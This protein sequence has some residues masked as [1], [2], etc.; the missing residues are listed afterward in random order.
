MIIVRLTGGLGNQ[1]FQY[2]MGRKLA[3]NHKTEL[4]LENSFYVNT[5]RK[6][7]PR[8]YEL[9][10]FSIKAR[11]T[12]SEERARLFFYTNSITKRVKKF[13]PSLGRFYFFA[14]QQLHK[15]NYL[16]L[17]RE[18][19]LDG[20]WQSEFFFLDIKKEIIEDFKI[21]P[22]MS[23]RDIETASKI[24]STN[25][26]SLHIRR[27]DYVSHASANSTHGFCGLD[28]YMKSISYIEQCTEK[29]VF[30][31]FSDDIEWTSKNLKINHPHFYV[32]HNNSDTAFQDLRLMSM[33]KHN[34][35]AN[36]SFSWW[37]AWLNQNQQKI[38]ISPKQWFANKKKDSSKITSES[39]ITF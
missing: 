18:T 8:K 7:T 23:A 17:P 1:L 5:P 32:D 36:S 3:L 26:I 29:P 19:F 21:I 35:I 24:T 13:F 10:N 12:T 31:I 20:Y 27:G 16:H 9:H 34:V 39:W 30:F 15:K 38:I 28:Y 4:I 37:G 2:A 6:A 33:C 25:S 22:A 14:E 11:C